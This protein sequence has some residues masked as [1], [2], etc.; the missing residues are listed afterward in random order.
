[1]FVVLSFVFKRW[2][3]NIKNV[4][5]K[6]DLERGESEVVTGQRTATNYCDAEL[7]YLKTALLIY[8]LNVFVYMFLNKYMH[9]TKLINFTAYHFCI[10][11]LLLKNK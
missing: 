3:Q 2:R 4:S 5:Q 10:L 6:T 1:M 8:M 7:R 9:N 11:S